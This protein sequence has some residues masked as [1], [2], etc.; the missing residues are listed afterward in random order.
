MQMAVK[1][2]YRRLFLMG[3]D[4][5][6]IVPSEASILDQDSDRRDKRIVLDSDSDPNHFDNRYFG[7]GKVWHTP[8][9]HLMNEH[10][11]KSF[12]ICKK[13]G[14]E[15]FNA[16]IGGELEVFPRISYEEAISI[17]EKERR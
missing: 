12:S 8:N 7:K 14:I 4:N 11:E 16:G 5:S 15:V 13:M 9:V 3:C 17:C 6:Y 10:Y 1:M 2:G